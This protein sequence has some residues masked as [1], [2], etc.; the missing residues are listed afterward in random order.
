MN[1]KNI[2]FADLETATPNSEYF[3]KHNDT[4]INVGYLENYEND[5]DNF[6]FGNVDEMIDWFYNKSKSV[7]V[8][9]HNLTWDG[10][11]ILKHLAKSNY[12]EFVNYEFTNSKMK[13]KQVCFLRQLNKIYNIKI[14][15]VGKKKNKITIDIKCSLNLLSSGVENL[16]KSVNIEKYQDIKNVKEF[17]DVE[18]QT[19]IS[20]YDKTYIDYLKRDI[21]IVKKSFKIFKNEMDIF[22]NKNKNK[23]WLY[24]FDYFKKYTIGSIAYEIQKRY[25][26]KF[27]DIKKGF[28]CS[29]AT[30]ELAQKFYF[31]GFTQFNPHIQNKVI[32]CKNGVGIDINSA[33]P[34]SM[35]KLLPY[36][37]MIN[38]KDEKPKGV[39]LEYLEIKINHAIAKFDNVPCLYNWK[40]TID[41]SLNRYVLYTNNITVYYLKQEWETLKKFYDFKGVKILNRWWCKASY[42]LKDYTNDL[43]SLKQK[44]SQENKKALANVYKILLNSSYGK[45]ATR[46]LFSEY[47]ICKN[48]TEYD[49]YLRIGEIYYNKQT[50]QVTEINDSLKL[51]NKFIIK[52]TP[53]IFKEFNYHKLIAA[54]ITSY[55]RIKILETILLLNPKNFLYCDT[56]SIYLKNV[57]EKLLSSLTHDSKLGYWKIEKRFKKFVV[58]GSKCYAVLDENAKNLYSKYSGINVKWLKDNWDLGFWK[59]QDIVLFNANLKK[60]ST[61]S[62]LVLVPVDYVP[63]KRYY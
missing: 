54:T 11:F 37:E 43:Y 28:K 2:Y 13:N 17:Y 57:D 56:D 27:N 40:K 3:K 20:K 24:N 29:L 38:F 8:Y 59:N 26:K 63:K 51:P 33:H 15:L 32:N 5:N 44:H 35:T 41:K 23:N 25:I 53:K 46:L 21:L 39:Y 16:G 9:F 18:Y 34:N 49:N 6:L 12:W 1:T 45:H 7:L 47:Y 10:D 52:I 36:G 48:K 22:L 4:I 19:D 42:F 31:G 30:Y 60:F 61:P 50:Y 55:T 14:C 62:G 58:S